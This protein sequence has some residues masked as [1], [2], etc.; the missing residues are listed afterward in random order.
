MCR[1]LSLYGVLFLANQRLVETTIILYGNV[2]TGTWALNAIYRLFGAKV[3]S[4]SIIRNK[5][6]AIL[7]PDVLTLG[8]K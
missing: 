3:G 2:V 4:H 1:R 5:T 7:V 8:D 6:P